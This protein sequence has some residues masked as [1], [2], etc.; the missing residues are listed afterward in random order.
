[1]KIFEA[2][3]PTAILLQL[4]GLNTKPS[5]MEELAIFFQENGITVINGDLPGHS[6]D[7]AQMRRVSFKDYLKRLDELLELTKGYDLPVYLLGFSLGALLS[8]IATQKIKTQK[9][10]LFAPPLY[11]RFFVRPLLFLRGPW[12]LKS[13][14]PFDYRAGD[15]TSFESYH[16]LSKFIGLAKKVVK[17]KKLP[18]T[19]LIINVDDELINTDKVITEFEKKDVNI[20]KIG[21]QSSY[22]HHLIID[23]TT[24]GHDAWNQLTKSL[25]AFITE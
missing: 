10:I 22:L 24:L 17:T 5:K 6:G 23:K 7:L 21:H 12:L 14:A 8:I 2:K 19:L 4:H 3:N 11:V 9:L 18:S 25:I 13:F 1:M 20:L 15:A 16:A